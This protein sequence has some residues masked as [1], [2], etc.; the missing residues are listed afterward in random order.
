MLNFPGGLENS[1][2]ACR[3]PRR[4]PYSRYFRFPRRRRR[5]RDLRHTTAARLSDYAA[6]A[7]KVRGL[8]KPAAPA[9]S[10]PS[11]S[12]NN[13]MFLLPFPERSGG[14]HHEEDRGGQAA[15]VEEERQAGRLGH[16]LRPARRHGRRS[17]AHLLG[18]RRLQRRG[19]QRQQSAA[20]RR[21]QVSILLFFHKIEDRASKVAS[22][23]NSGTFEFKKSPRTRPGG[24]PLIG[25]SRCRLNVPRHKFKASPAQGC[26]SER[27]PGE[28]GCT[29]RGLFTTLPL[30]KHRIYWPRTIQ[31]Q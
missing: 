16:R 18:Q 23:T 28:P 3:K 29:F 17:Q 22:D 25:G 10:L 21:L 30:P 15:G 1:A 14:L 31:V 26:R 7:A 20:E 4:S 27:W 9:G 8:T 2:R 5:R 13:R 6:A 24:A 11:E 12:S 19:R